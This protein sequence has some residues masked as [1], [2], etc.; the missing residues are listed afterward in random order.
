MAAPFNGEDLNLFV[1][2]HLPVPG[3][4]PVIILVI[5]TA[6]LTFVYC[7]ALQIF[8]KELH[9]SVYK[10]GKGGTKEG[11]SLFGMLFGL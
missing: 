10:I 5:Q 4:T 1:A 2:F 8:Q 6:S 7:S 9:P 3:S 11:L